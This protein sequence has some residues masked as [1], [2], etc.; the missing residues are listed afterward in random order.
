MKNILSK[1]QIDFWTYILL[2]FALFAGYIKVVFIIFL[3][4][5]I[6]ELGHI[7]FLMLFHISIEKVK[8][9][10]FGGLTI[11]N[12]RLHERIY[13]DI[14]VGFGGIIFQI[15]LY[16]I[17]FFLFKN[18][19]ILESTYLIF[20]KYNK[21]LILFNL[22]PII[23]LDG[24]K[25]INAF[26]NLFISFKTSYF[27]T[28]LV[29]VGTLICFIIFNFIF[30]IN[31]MVIYLFFLFQ[32]IQVIKEFKLVMNKFYLERVLYNHYYNRIINKCSDLDRLR[33][34]KYYYFFDNRRYI[35]EKD[36][37]RKRLF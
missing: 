10:P 18:G 27:V 13:K 15:V 21:M 17:V 4:V 22:L 33:I 16:V 11:I 30:R 31:D 24:S 34:D 32:L 8:I 5:F 3:I 7:F 1:F 36:Y 37:I 35:N 28:I 29:S 23:P 20:V 25:I 9:Y 2:F 26:L 6:H 12:K 19:L 14:I